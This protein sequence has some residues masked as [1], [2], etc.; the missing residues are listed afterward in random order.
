VRSPRGTW[1]RKIVAR[2]LATG[3]LFLRIRVA[4]NNLGKRASA[5]MTDGIEKARAGRLGYALSIPA[6]FAKNKRERLMKMIAVA[7]FAAVSLSVIAGLAHS[8]VQ[9]GANLLPGRDLQRAPAPARRDAVTTFSIGIEANA[10]F[11]RAGDTVTFTI[12]VKPTGS[13]PVAA[14]D[15]AIANVLP[16]EVELASRPL[17]SFGSKDPQSLCTYE[18]ASRTVTA[19]TASLGDSAAGAKIVY[20]VRVRADLQC[21]DAV[22]NAAAVTWRDSSTAPPQTSKT[23]ATMSIARGGDGSCPVALPGSVIG[24]AGIES[25]GTPSARSNYINSSM[26]LDIPRLGL[27]QMDIV[28]VPLSNGTWDISWLGNGAGWLQTTATPGQPGNSVITAHVTDIYGRDGPFAQ[29]QTL[30]VGDKILVQASGVVSTYLVQ[31]V[32]E[33]TPDDMSVLGDS[34]L[35]LLTLLTCAEPNYTTHTYDARLVVQ[36]LMIRQDA[37]Q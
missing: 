28:E 23:T 22:V 2:P 31:S 3:V 32:R 20:A 21:G 17:C 29:L 1:L 16:P 15:V 36:A 24:A 8:P 19:R 6:V 34:G 9:T 14:T 25:L 33:V 30:G 27:S 10:P 5:T 35:P 26:F 18:A 11:L 4:L 7:A 37:Q 12:T 13:N